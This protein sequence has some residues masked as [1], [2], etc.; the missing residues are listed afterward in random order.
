MISYKPIYHYTPEK[1]WMNDPNGVIWYKGEYHLFY[2][3]NPYGPNWGNIHWGHAKSTDLVHWEHLPIAIYPSIEKGEH[4]CFSGCAVINGDMPTIFYTSVGI[5]DRHQSIG[6]EQWMATSDDDMLTWKKYEDN[7]ALS[8]DIHKG[9]E[10]TEWRDPFV[11]KESNLWYMVLGGCTAGHGGVFLYKSEN[12]TEWEFLNVM[13]EGPE[14]YFECP[15]YFKIG[16]KSVLIYSPDDIVKYAIGT[17]GEDYKFTSEVEGVLD[18]S[19]WEGF[20][21]PNSLTDPTGRRI[22][23]GWLTE[24]ARGDLK[25]E[26]DWAGV[27]SIPRVL[28]MENNT[29]WQ[30]PAEEL[31]SLRGDSECY[32]DISVINSL[33]TK[34]NGGALELKLEV[35]SDELKDFEIDLFKSNTIDE[36]TTVKY[37][38]KSNRIFIDRSKS[39]ATGL[40]H[41]S[42]LDCKVELAAEES[43]KLHIFI[44]NSTI[45]V[46]AN[47]RECISTRVYPSSKDSNNVSL[48]VLNTTELKVKSFE[49]WE[50][51]SIW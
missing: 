31:M 7:P 34:I 29:L 23:F 40:C 42:I 27:Q 32:I 14:R 19:G 30:N 15:N 4:H 18:H 35:T 22:V 48:N 21:A 9:L 13:Y 28:T 26:L 51:K 17:L 33:Q 45:E 11:W 1:N 49:I 39:N 12:L 6:A 46:F 24:N 3:H 16:D 20:Y 43:L 8:L 2:Q 10:V 36:K 41:N 47:S 25:D 44:D 38:S 5:E 37:D 50:M